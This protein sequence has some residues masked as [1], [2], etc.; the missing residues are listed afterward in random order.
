MNRIDLQGRRAV[1]TGGAQGIGLAIARRFVAS[2]A[3]VVIWDRQQDQAAQAAAVL[4][5]AASAR[6]LDLTDDAAVAKAAAEAGAVDILVNNAGITGGN[7]L[8]WDLD[9]AGWRQ[10]MEVNLNAPFVVC[11]ALVPGMIARGY[12]RIVNIASIAGKEGNPNAA[13]YS[14][15]KAGLISLT[16]S[17]GKELAGTGVIANCITPAAARTPIFDQMTQQHIDYML[18]KIPLARFLEP[19]EVAALVAWLSSEDCSFSTGAVFDISG[20]RATY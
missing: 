13:H 4:G 18:S 17:L 8:L 12:G 20:G 5:P 7:G 10:V 16:K 14:A 2:G 3:E 9:P 1:V 6:A 15:S 19:D 11:R